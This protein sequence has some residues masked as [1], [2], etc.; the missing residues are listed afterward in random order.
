MLRP[1]IIAL[2]IC[3]AAC[4][5]QPQNAPPASVTLPEIASGAPYREARKQ[6]IA[7]GFIPQRVLTRKLYGGGPSMEAGWC[8][9]EGAGDETMCI[10]LPEMMSCSMGMHTR[11]AFLYRHEPSGRFAEVTTRC[12]DFE[13]TYCFEEITWDPFSIEDYPSGGS[14]LKPR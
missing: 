12:M 4:W 5:P 9:A 11:C 3:V 7:K 2:S 13:R 8:P 10:E 1:A 6:L 14:A